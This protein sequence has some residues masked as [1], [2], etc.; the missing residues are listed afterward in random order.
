M[1]ARVENPLFVSRLAVGVQMSHRRKGS[2]MVRR[3]TAVF[4]RKQEPV[5]GAVLCRPGLLLS[6]EHLRKAPEGE[7][8]E[9]LPP[10]RVPAKAG[11]HWERCAVSPWVPAFAGALRG[12]YVGAKH[13]AKPL[14][15]RGG[16]WGGA[17]RRGGT[18]E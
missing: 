18:V 4:L 10:S 15:F 16:V 7:G 9:V 13:N 5:G 3:C 2:V 14:S 12:R 17:S 6:Q 8:G 1:C 11:T